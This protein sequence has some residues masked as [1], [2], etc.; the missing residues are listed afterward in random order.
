MFAKLILILSPAF[1]GSIAGAVGGSLVSNLLGPD[2]PSG[3]QYS[4]GGMPFYQPTWQAGADKAWQDLF[5]QAQTYAQNATAGTIPDY[6][7]SYYALQGI[8]YQPFLQ[9]SQQAGQQ[10]GNLA[11]L[12]QQQ[13]GIYGG[14]AGLAGLE[15]QNLYGAGNQLWQTALDPQSA[16]YNRTVQ[17]LQDQV[18]SGQ[19]ARGLGTSAV[20]GAEENQAL[21]N[22]N[23]DW[24]NQQLA[25]Q[26][27]GLQGMDAA[28]R[29]GGAQ[30]Q[31]VGANLAGQMG[32]AGQVPTFLQQQAQVPLSA[33][34]YAYGQPAA[35]AGQFQQN[36][37]NAMGLLNQQMNQA[38]PYLNYGQ[39]ASQNAYNAFAGQQ[40]V[41]MQQNAALGNLGS[42]IGQGI[43]NWAQQSY[44]TPGSWLNNMFGNSGSGTYT[45]QGVPVGGL[46]SAQY[47]PPLQ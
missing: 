42:Q 5:K 12:A 8:N 22:F 6:R 23:I 44:N 36:I 25:R 17:Q 30:G 27:Q 43:G 32:V 19:A 38:I 35:V 39:G 15:Q 26:L 11:N 34:Q 33:Q 1:I 20:G 13:A 2:V 14:Q 29:A 37:G 31:L 4:Q 10:Y 24:Q 40:N 41:A 21:S 18:R 28:S 47:L 16:L 46:T 45:D 7:K 9:A 3:S